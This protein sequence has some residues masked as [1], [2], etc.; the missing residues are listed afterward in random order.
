M[1]MP[2]DETELREE[3]IREEHQRE[4]NPRAHWAYLFGVLT[5]GLV[6]MLALIAFLGRTA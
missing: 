5:G 2:R 3:D 6:L 4:I 1:T